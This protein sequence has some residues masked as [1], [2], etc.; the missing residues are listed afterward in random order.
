MHPTPMDKT[1]PTKTWTSY[2]LRDATYTCRDHVSIRY[3]RT[4]PGLDGRADWKTDKT[5]APATLT[6][7]I[8]RRWNKI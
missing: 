5:C 1:S 6:N 3:W 7:E 8:L 2:G 4:A